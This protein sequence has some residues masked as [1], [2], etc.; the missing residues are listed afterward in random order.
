MNL[1]EKI[2]FILAI[3]FIVAGCVSLPEEIAKTPSHAY[4]DTNGTRIGFAVQPLLENRDAGTGLLP[5]A[6]GVD[7]FTARYLLAAAAERSLDVQ[8]YIWHSD[9]TG[10]LLLYALLE[11]AGRGVR[12]R[13]L[14]DDIN[15]AGKDDALSAL[16]FHPNIEIRLFNPF[17]NRR[18]RAMGFITDF[19]RVNRRM[20]NKS[21]TIDN[22]VTIV[23]GRN[24]G[25]EY[26]DADPSMD[27][28]DFDLLAI[29]DVVR[30]VSQQFD[31]YWNSEFAV[32]VDALLESG[33]GENIEG[34]KHRLEQHVVEVSNSV[35][36]EA[37][38]KSGLIENIQ[39]NKLKY[40]WDEAVVLY[41]D[42]EKIRLD[43]DDSSSHLLSKIQP[44]LNQTQKEMLIISPYFI[45]GEK[46]V[47]RLQASR[48]R[49]LEIGVLTNSLSSTDV[50]LVHSGY[51]VYREPLLSAGVELYEMK[52]M[53]RPEKKAKSF[54][55]GSRSSLHSKIYVFD[56]KNIFVGSF[57][58][59]PRSAKI[60]TE[61][62]IYVLNTELAR[63]F[64]EWWDTSMRKLAYA[65]SLD[66]EDGR[67]QLLWK[68]FS[69]NPV[70]QYDKEPDT[71]FWQRIKSDLLS[72]LPVE[73]QL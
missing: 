70:K 58:L 59:D 53:L 61:M 65:L 38:R 19:S 62:G 23:G 46:G 32:P 47:E 26:F 66:G 24:V 56:R 34:I 68:D 42:P 13:L 22:Q 21:F 48:E 41:D 10:K 60:N 73:D 6:D 12:V 18:F 15:L 7:A 16:H 25:D 2:L 72:I 40:F 9:T 8:Y 44:L 67:Q 64:S 17:A 43:A 20:H 29:G 71:S 52:S 14:L 57:N 4:Q 11:A 1:M 55:A 63:L 50:P 28:H 31:V 37:I 69:V 49:G 30:D 45:P 5:L 33:R 51:A 54:S 3:Q 36:A 39:Q 27:F 35:Y